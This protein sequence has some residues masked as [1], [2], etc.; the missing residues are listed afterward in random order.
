MSGSMHGTPFEVVRVG[1]VSS[2]DLKKGTARVVFED[3]DDAVS[4]E[5]SVMQRN[6]MN[7]KSYWMPDV[8]EMVV[9]FFLPN[10]QETGFISGSYY[11]DADRP[12]PEISDEGKKRWGIWVDENNY[13]KWVEEERRFVVKTENPIDWVV[14]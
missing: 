2:V 9:C 14:G 12:V 10:G 13:I 6:T 8:N 3:R 4:P 5:L 1:V 11:S 7:S